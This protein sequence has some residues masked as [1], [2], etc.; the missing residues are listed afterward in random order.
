MGL[1]PAV[2]LEGFTQFGH[3]VE[4]NYKID[5]MTIRVDFQRKLKGLRFIWPKER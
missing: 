2:C 4:K 5:E 1:S 3:N